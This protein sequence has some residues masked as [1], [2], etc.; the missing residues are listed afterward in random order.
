YRHPDN[1]A[2]IPR[3]GKGN[4]HTDHR[5]DQHTDIGDHI[6]DG[7]QHGQEYRIFDTD[8]KKSRGIQRRYNGQFDQQPDHITLDDRPRFG[9][10]FFDAGAVTGGEEV[11]EKFADQAAVVKDQESVDRQ[12]DDHGQ[13]RSRRKESI[14]QHARPGVLQIFGGVFHGLV[15]V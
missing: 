11:N 10:H 3:I 12:Q 9:K 4:Q 6:E 7:G 13:R 15:L 14:A 8:D 1:I 5:S 2:E